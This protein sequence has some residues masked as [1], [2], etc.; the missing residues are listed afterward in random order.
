[1][2]T[3]K[4]GGRLIFSRTH[5]QLMAA[6]HDEAATDFHAL[7]KVLS[8]LEGIEGTEAEMLPAGAAW[9]ALQYVGQIESERV[10]GALLNWQT[11]EACA[12]EISRLC[13]PSF[14]NIAMHLIIELA[15]QASIPS[16]VCGA[17]RCAQEGARLRR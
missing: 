3:D 4:R 1:M 11:V 2:K 9:R 7:Y 13:P 6:L 10:A 5:W 16:I 15:L 14:Y 8:V 12:G 17:P